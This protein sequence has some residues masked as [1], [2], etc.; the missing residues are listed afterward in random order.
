MKN[1]NPEIA[2]QTLMLQGQCFSA[3]HFADACPTPFFCTTPALQELYA[4]LHE[5]F[6]NQPYVWVQTS[7]STGMPKRIKVSKQ[8][9][10][11]S[12]AGTCR[13]LNLKAGNV[14]L[15]CMNLQYIGAK[16][17]VVRA[18]VAGLELVVREASGKPLT[19]VPQR[20][21]FAAFVPMQIFEC[22][23]DNL[24]KERLQNISNVL[25]G[26]G[27]L[28][29]DVL[30]E[31]RTFPNRIFSTYGMTETLSHIALMQ[32]SGAKA[33]GVYTPMWGIELSLSPRGTLIIQN[34]NLLDAPLET[35]DLAELYPDG[36]FRIL[37]RADNVINSGGVKIQTEELEQ[38]LRP[39]LPFAFAIGSQAD[40]KFGEIVVLLS[41]KAVNI[42]DLKGHLP[43]YYLPKKNIVVPQIPL[44]ET[45]KIDRGRIKK[46][47]SQII[48]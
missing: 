23:K 7:G 36:T 1:M 16:M 41:T 20:I 18:L 19:D 9:M 8:R 13:A 22:L 12:A 48:C 47:L 24:Q 40:N 17:M 21:D 32:V 34:E 26:G 30:A 33:S 25:V 6:D 28:A 44:T 14:A 43:A 4:F 27:A 35:N 3:S 39:H 15:L 42:N 5:W 46:L 37:G 29:D 31:L 38:L 11:Y 2:H 10:M 45:G